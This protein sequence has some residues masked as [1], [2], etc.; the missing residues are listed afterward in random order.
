LSRKS[1]WL[2]FLLAREEFFQEE[3][4]YLHTGK[5]PVECLPE[6]GCQR[7]AGWFLTWSDIGA[8]EWNLAHPFGTRE[9]WA[10]L[11]PQFPVDQEFHLLIPSDDADWFCQTYSLPRVELLHWHCDNGKESLTD[12]DLV[13]EIDFENFTLKFLEN[14]ENSPEGG[15]GFWG[16]KGY[17]LRDQSIVSLVKTIHVTPR[18][19]EVYIETLPEFRD[20]GLGSFLLGE[21]Q[22]RIH[23]RGLRMIYVVSADNAPSLRVA[24]KRGL[25][26][27]QTLA[28]IPYMKKSQ[29]R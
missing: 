20:R 25:S 7:G 26:I 16:L 28:R 21:M 17:V 5:K 11:L 13:K 12:S 29:Q 18:T 3:I 19:A 10:S 8:G 15:P 23:N 27:Y 1:E 2:A 6:D 22:K 9:D 14:P 24:A 4:H